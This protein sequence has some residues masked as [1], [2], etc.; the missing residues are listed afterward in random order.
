MEKNIFKI[1]VQEKYRFS[2]EKGLL[3]VEQIFGLSQKDLDKA[4]RSSHARITELGG[5]GDDS[6]DLQFLDGQG[7]YSKELTEERNKFEILKE[8]WTDRKAE[9]IVNL[10]S[11]EKREKKENLMA[12]LARKKESELEGKS[13]EEIESMIKSLS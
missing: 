12:I 5:A 4:I 3:T 9:A 6:S 7:S 1:A 11:R 2:T 13:I 8:I 10:E